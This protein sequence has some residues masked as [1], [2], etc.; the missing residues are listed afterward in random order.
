M[1]LE[2]VFARASRRD[3]GVTLVE[4]L[5]A[6]FVVSV[7]CLGAASA[8][9]YGIQA[10]RYAERRTYAVFVGR[11]MLNM[12]RARNEP[13]IGPLPAIGSELNDGDYDDDGDD[14]GPRRPFNAPP[15]ENDFPDNINYQRR[16]E[17]KRMSN[18]PN[19]H[20]SELTAIKVT[21]FWNEGASEKSVTLRGFHKR[22]G[23]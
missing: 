19:S 4:V 9:W 17:M 13:F 8:L 16:I 10:E 14:N 20:L 11:E 6:I 1:R 15:F 18:N 23:I 5:I 3:R 21:L 7:G 22:S 12:I 2:D